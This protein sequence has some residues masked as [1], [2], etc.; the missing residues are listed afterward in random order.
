MQSLFGISTA[1][2]ALWLAIFAG[3]SIL[4][5][6]TLGFLQK[7]LVKLSLRNI[8]RRTAQSI[9][10]IIGLMLLDLIGAWLIH[11][12]EHNVKWMWKFHIIHHTDKEVDVTTGLR[13]H[14]GLSLIHI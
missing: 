11:W 7:I 14:P 10:I 2:L 6:L 4:L 1:T 12:I 9:L 5:I 3:T 8:P 13:H